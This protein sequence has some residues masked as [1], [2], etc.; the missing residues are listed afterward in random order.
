MKI[1]RINMD[2]QTA[3]KLRYDRLKETLANQRK[4]KARARKARILGIAVVGTWILAPALLWR[5]DLESVARPEFFRTPTPHEAYLLSLL[6]REG[7]SLPGP[8]APSLARAWEAASYHALDA[9]LLIGSAYREVG[10]FPS[11]DPQALGLKVH[12]PAGQRLRLRIEAQTGDSN[13][14]AEAWAGNAIRGGEGEAGDANQV[15]VDLF[16]AAPDS[17]LHGEPSP[18]P[19]PA[20]LRSGEMNDGGWTFDAAE[21]GDYVLRLQPELEGLVRYELSVQVGAPWRFPVAGAGERDIGSFFGDSRD[22]GTRDHHGVDIFAPRGTPALAAADGYVRT[23]DTTEIGGRVVW[24]REAGGQYSIYYAHLDRPLVR[25]GQRLR[26]GDTVGLVGNTGNARTTPPHLHFGAYR[27]GPQDPWDLILPIPPTLPAVRVSLD[28]LGK[29]YRVPEAGTSLR[30]SPSVR[31]GSVAELGGSILFRVLAGSG[32]WYRVLLGDGTW[33]FVEAR[34]TVDV[35][36]SEG[37]T[38]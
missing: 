2:R 31:D 36:S 14:G 24:Q 19:R 9:P 8:P 18:P 26:A 29:R 4:A 28:A 33:G 15:F 32:D 37:E 34:S 27:R 35:Q 5:V 7:S 21:T 22:G 10:T 25:E 16:R 17:L 3:A 38:R 11:D 20:H 13:R 23:V 30:S 6:G 1:V 12:I